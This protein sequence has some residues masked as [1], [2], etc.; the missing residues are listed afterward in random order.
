MRESHRELKAL[1]WTF[2]KCHANGEEKEK[3]I[4]MGGSQCTLD[5]RGHE[6]QWG[7]E[8]ALATRDVDVDLLQLFTKHKGKKN[9]TV[10]YQH[11][12]QINFIMT[13][14]ATDEFVYFRPSEVME[15]LA[16]SRLVLVGS[17]TIVTISGS[18]LILSHP[19]AGPT[20]RYL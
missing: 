9:E 10:D 6:Y 16:G 2:I 3:W 14:L 11:S 7:R 8:D 20:C 17:R 15:K 12:Q 18:S 5:D 1:Q 19:L 13:N 4:L